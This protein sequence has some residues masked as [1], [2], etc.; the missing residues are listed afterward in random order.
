MKFSSCYLYKDQFF[1]V[2]WD[3]PDLLQNVKRVNP[4]LVELVSSIPAIH[5]SPFSPPRKK[6]RLP[7]NPDFSMAGQ[8]QMPL[9]SSNF[10]SSNSPMCCITD[11]IPAGIQGARHALLEPSSSDLHFNKLQSGLFPMGFQQLD[12]ADPPRIPSANFMQSTENNENISRWLK[13][14]CPSETLKADNE[15]KMPHIFLFGQLILAEQNNSSCS[16]EN[17]SSDG[18]PEKTSNLSDG[19]GTASRR[20]G[21][22]EN[23]SDGGSPWYKDH[24]R[25]DLSLETGH[26]KVFLE[27]EDVGRTLDLSVFSSYQEL[28]GK[29]ADMFGIK[30]SEMLSNVLYRDAAGSIKHTG[31]E[32]FR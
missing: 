20:N 5:M 25:S 2:A 29:L 9:I 27:S 30:S 16:G 23:S 26:C 19:S 15:A 21:S 24:Q 22:V 3:E 4:W 13:M 17:S 32:P 7:Q 12:H 11:N 14:G 18:N 31:D 1:Q 6:L 10:L 8:Y 28:Y